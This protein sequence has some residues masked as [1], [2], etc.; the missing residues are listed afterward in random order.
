[1]VVSNT[2]ISIISLNV[3]GFNAPIKRQKL[4]EQIKKQHPIIYCLQET[5]LKYEDTF[6]FKEMDGKK[7]TMLTL[8]Q[9]KQ[10]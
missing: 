9:I 5:H 10:K 3:T 2:A 7:Y 8:I 6:R 4:S 1:M